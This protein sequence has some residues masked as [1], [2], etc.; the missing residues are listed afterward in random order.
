M[1]VIT[2]LFSMVTEN[3]LIELVNK[4]DRKFL[5]SM[6]AQWIKANSISSL[7]VRVDFCLSLIQQVWTILTLDTRINLKIM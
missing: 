3:V 6:L 2:I 4:P 7:N 1:E 5:V